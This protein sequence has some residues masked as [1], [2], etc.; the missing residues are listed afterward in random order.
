MTDLAL[1]LF[2]IL[3]VDVLN[4]V[5]FAVMIVAVSSPRPVAN[6]TAL[7]A[8]HTV[9]YF[10]VGIVVALGL[11]RVS[12]RLA[13]PEPVDFVIEFGIGLLCL[14]AALKSRDG[15]ASEE[16]QPDK[17][18]TPLV[19]FG[20]GAV[21]N[22]TGAPF[23]VPY[24]AAVGQILGESLSVAASLAMLGIYNIGYALPFALVPILVAVMGDASK[25]ILEKINAVLISIADR[26]MPLLMLLLGLAFI[27]D[28]VSYLALGESLF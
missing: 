14:W 8:G 26:L 23:A 3:L 27:T 17:E 5:L 20:F 13:N 19:C 4:P 24:F 21:V 9:A 28:A 12:A 6:S 7:L 11:D 25:P 2:P 10:V 15:G 1:T 18:L 22:F 16:K